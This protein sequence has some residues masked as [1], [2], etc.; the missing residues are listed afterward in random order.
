MRGEVFAHFQQ[1]ERAP[2]DAPIMQVRFSD[3][4]ASGFE[5]QLQDERSAS[6]RWVSVSLIVASRGTL[7]SFAD[8]P[9]EFDLGVRMSLSGAFQFRQRFVKVR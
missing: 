7:L 6:L 3:P 8:L 5:W 1:Q 2:S 9:G 4:G